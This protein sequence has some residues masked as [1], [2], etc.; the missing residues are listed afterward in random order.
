PLSELETAEKGSVSHTQR[1][2]GEFDWELLHRAAFLN[3][4]TDIALTFVDYLSIKNRGAY[5]FDQLD[6]S[7]IQFIERV[8]LV[9]QARVSLISTR[10]SARL[11][12]RR[13]W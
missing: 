6:A 13:R 4:P 5:R 3:R 9:A 8:E 2:V 12:D 7:T 11:I 1:R 10:F